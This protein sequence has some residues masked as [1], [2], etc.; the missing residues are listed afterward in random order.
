MKKCQIASRTLRNHESFTTS[1]VDAWLTTDHNFVSSFLAVS[2]AR[3]NLS[4]DKNKL[5]TYH[6]PT[7][8]QF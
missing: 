4:E 1:S 2:N 8:R 6:E 5:E 7:I 3:L